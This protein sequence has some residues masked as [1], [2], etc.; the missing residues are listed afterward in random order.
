MFTEEIKD[1][2]RTLASNI[3]HDL[4]ALAE[5]I[6]EDTGVDISG[7]AGFNDVLNNVSVI[8]NLNKLGD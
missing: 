1:C 2:T 8:R 7:Y 4:C 3:D 5:K 6:M